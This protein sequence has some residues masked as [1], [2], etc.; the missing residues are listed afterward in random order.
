MLRKFLAVILFLTFSALATQAQSQEDCAITLTTAIDEFNAGHF[1]NISSILNECLG[2]FTR[3]QRE[4]AYMLLTQTYLLLDDPFAAEQSYLALLKAN[5]EFLADESRDPIDV[6][7]LSKKFTAT[8]ILSWYLNIGANVSS[9]TVLNSFSTVGG[10][11]KAKEYSV[12]PGLQIGGGLEYNYN[13]NIVAVAEVNYATTSYKVVQAFDGEDKIETIDRQ[14]WFNVPI[15]FKYA[16]NKGKFR[17]YGYGGYSFNFLVN[18]VLTT[19]RQNE[20]NFT[21]AESPDLDYTTHR[22]KVNRSF[23]FGGGLRYK[24]GLDFLFADIRL[25][26]GTT[27]LVKAGTRHNNTE[28]VFTYGYVEDDFR[29][30]SAFVSVGFVHPLYKPRKLKKAR[31]RSV[32]RNIDK[33]SDEEQN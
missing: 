7:Y 30:N 21:T 28:G 32:Q 14:N 19:Q 29:I 5:P 8:P 13:D 16:V 27:N 33:Q 26:V 22:K 2:S 4:R 24:F 12:R 18:D 25:S 20:S 31:T 15:M 9:I 3:E 17:P 11:R 6:V 23:V 10:E 1:N